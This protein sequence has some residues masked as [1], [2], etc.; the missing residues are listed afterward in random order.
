MTLCAQVPQGAT[1]RSLHLQMRG[2]LTRCVKPGDSVTIT[3]I[4]LTEPYTGFKAMRAGLLTSTYTE[5]M[6]VEHNKQSYADLQLSSDKDSFLAVS[7][8]HHSIML[9][10]ALCSWSCLQCTLS[11][12]AMA[13][14]Q[15]W[16]HRSRVRVA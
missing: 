11:L 9:M 4:H 2:E 7:A 3:G 8:S 15:I 13:Y 16:I 14:M 6:H 1:P 5:A 10:L 12:V